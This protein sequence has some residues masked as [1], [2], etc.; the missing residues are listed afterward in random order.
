MQ[1]HPENHWGLGEP[2][3]LFPGM[4]LRA[5]T[6]SMEVGRFFLHC[7]LE[8]GPFFA[9]ESPFI[10][11][12]TATPT[13]LLAPEPPQN[14]VV[15]AAGRMLCTVGAICLSVQDVDFQGAQWRQH[16][17]H[18]SDREQRLL[19]LHT[20]KGL[21]RAYALNSIIW[22]RG[23]LCPL[24]RPNL[25]LPEPSVPGTTEERAHCCRGWRVSHLSWLWLI[26][27]QTMQAKRDLFWLLVSEVSV[28]GH[29]ALD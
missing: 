5:G 15:W 2:G 22:V 18:C 20:K 27:T 19:A 23:C 26:S 12:L 21:T 7:N 25:V 1:L 24:K 16:R 3:A 4:E 13:C 29:V 28:H 8:S 9:H 17:L 14:R 6:K 10:K 11:L